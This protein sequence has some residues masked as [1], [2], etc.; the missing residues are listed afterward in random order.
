M[1]IAISE[2]LKVDIGQYMMKVFTL[3]GCSASAEVVTPASLGMNYIV[4]GNASWTKHTLSAGSTS[5]NRMV[6]VG[7]SAGGVNIV[8]STGI[9]ADGCILQVWGY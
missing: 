9:S 1:A 2:N 5:N 7:S 8:L 3:T 4:V 6:D